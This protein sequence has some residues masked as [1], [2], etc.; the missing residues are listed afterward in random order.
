[1]RYVR[2]QN[3][4]IIVSKVLNFNQKA[5]PDPNAKYTTMDKFLKSREIRGKFIR[6]KNATFKLFDNISRPKAKPTNNPSVYSEKKGYVDN[7]PDVKIFL[8]A[9]FLISIEFSIIGIHALNN[10][11]SLK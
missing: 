3:T 6:F 9:A 1:M 11:S 10:C 5:L 7:K 8:L 4:N 2:K